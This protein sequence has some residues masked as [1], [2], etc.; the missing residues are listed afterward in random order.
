MLYGFITNTSSL[1]TRN[2]PKGAVEVEEKINH[3]DHL[4]LIWEEGPWAISEWLI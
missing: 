3:T 4:S 1:G 2:G